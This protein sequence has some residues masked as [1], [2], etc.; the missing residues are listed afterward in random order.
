MHSLSCN[1]LIEQIFNMQIEVNID[2]G[3][4]RSHD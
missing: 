3:R 4:F 1:V 2:L